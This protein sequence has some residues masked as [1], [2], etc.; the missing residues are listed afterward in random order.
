MSNIPERQVLVS[1]DLHKDWNAF[2]QHAIYILKA[3]Q[4][5]IIRMPHRCHNPLHSNVGKLDY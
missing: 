1:D 3:L 5:N 2:T 4:N